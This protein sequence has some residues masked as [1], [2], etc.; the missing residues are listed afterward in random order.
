MAVEL[1][2]L[3]VTLEANFARYN[4]DMNRAQGVTNQRLASMERRFAAFGRNSSASIGM[5][6]AALGSLGTYLTADQLLGYANAW[7]R[8]ERAVKAGE[9]VFG[10]ALKSAEELNAL[11]NDARIDVE[12]YTKLYVRTSAAIR[13]Y[14]FEAGTAEKVTST[15][16]KALKLGGAAASEQASVLL[17]FSQALQKGKLDGDEFRSVMENAGVVQELLADR[18]KVSKGEIV[19][20]AAEGKLKVTQLVSAMT[21]G[22]DM[23]DRLFRGVP[24]TTDEAW[25]VLNNSVSQYV[26]K[27]DKTYGI[28]SSVVGV[29][30]A[31]ARNIETVGDAALVLAAGFTAAFAPA[32]LAGII[33]AAGA[34][35]AMAGPLGILIG[36][37]AG[38]AAAVGIYGDRVKLS[39]D[40]TFSLK[41]GVKGLVEALTEAETSTRKFDSAITLAD[42]SVVN[43]GSDL[44]R[45]GDKVESFTDRVKRLAEAAAMEKTLAGF[46]GKLKSYLEGTL[47]DRPPLKKGPPPKDDDGKKRRNAYEREIDAIKKRIEATEAEA[48]VVGQ[49]AAVQEKARVTQSLMTAARQADVKITPAVAAAIDKLAASYAKAASEVAY[50]NALQGA[51]ETGESIQREISLIGKQG[52]ELARA[53]QQ[54]ELL[55][56][57]KRAGIELTPARMA[58]ID[59]IAR[60]NAALEHTLEIMND[61]RDQSADAIKGF[62]A[63]L[64]EGKSAA[65]ALSGVLNKIADKLIDMAVNDLVNGALGAFNQSGGGMSLAKIFGFADGGIAAHG[66][67]VPLPRFARG[68]VSSSAAIFGEAGPEAAVPLPDGRRI[69]V[70]LRMPNMPS[71]SAPMAHGP[72]SVTVAPVFN[73]ENGT[74]EGIDKLKTEIV[75]LIRQ[76]AK[77]EVATIFDRS[78]QFRKLKG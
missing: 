17:Q 34:V 46:G 29:T 24:A 22:A 36:L 45:V 68:G 69:P 8:V 40:H 65:E 37:F 20:M 44:D 73:V 41:D 2:R 31:L 54:Q 52:L 50:L 33:G 66:R 3:L 63:D 13:D 42:G 11:A 57:A 27:L 28:T 9:V 74:A 30:T 23:V 25:Q 10:M 53:R 64:R 16:A 55:N 38:G 58:E 72:T 7:I 75:P 60:Q 5:V 61:I 48:R 39:S 51:R 15:L 49:S 1:D 43:M 70:E 19:K 21:Q 78:A 4:A 26:G 12:A 32:I 35:A 67:P 18:L 14:G 56:E 71:L 59:A 6:G 76:V 77:S 62:I 47:Q